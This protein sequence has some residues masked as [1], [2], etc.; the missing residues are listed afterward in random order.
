MNCEKAKEFIIKNARPLELEFYRYFFENSSKESVIEELKKYQNP[1]GGFGHGLEADNWNINS[2]PIATNDA[3]ITLYRIDA[4]DRNNKMVQ[5]IVKYLE[6]HDSFNE[7]EKRWLFAIESNKEYPHAVWWEKKDSD[8][9]NGYNPTVSLAAF[10]ICFG[11]NKSYYQD[12][13]RDAFSFLEKNEEIS[14][15]ALK[16][17]L[18][19][20]EL[21]RK[22]E[23]KNIIDLEKIHKLLC[24]R[25]DNT[26]CKDTSKYCV[27]YVPVPSDFFDGMYER[28]VTKEIQEL[29]DTEKK[30]LEKMQSDDGGFDIS[31]EWYN[32]YTEFEQA[33]DW[34][35]PRITIDK[36]LFYRS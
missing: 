14:G 2:N 7:Q 16:C 27:E 9:I 3:I 24:T 20:Y 28:F 33:R 31:W 34:W 10:L 23:I 4:L 15:D 25:I 12:I 19:S 32:D 21:I 17:F 35:R 11:E 18:L 26:I 6:S 29:I 36:L 13:V 22:Y 1:D 5:E 30:L 8:G